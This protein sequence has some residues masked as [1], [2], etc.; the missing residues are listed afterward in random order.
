MLLCFHH[1]ILLMRMLLMD[2]LTC[3]YMILLP[4]SQGVSTHRSVAKLLIVVMM[5]G[6]VFCHRQIK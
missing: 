5:Q 1:P 4:I 2:L 3:V 6:I